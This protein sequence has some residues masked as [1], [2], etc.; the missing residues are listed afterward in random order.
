MNH[1]CL[2]LREESLIIRV[3]EE[4]RSEDGTSAIRKHE[5][6]V[7]LLKQRI[8]SLE[9]VSRACEYVLIIREGIRFLRDGIIRVV[10]SRERVERTDL[11]PSSTEFRSRVHSETADIHTGHRDGEEIEVE[12]L[13][14]RSLE[15]LPHRSVITCPVLHVLS[16]PSNLR[17]RDDEW[18]SVSHLLQ[19]VVCGDTLSEP[20]EVV[21]V[22]LSQ[23]VIREVDC[24]RVWLVVLRC[25]HRHSLL[26]LRVV[27]AAYLEGELR[28]EVLHGDAE[29]L[30]VNWCFGVVRHDALLIRS[31]LAVHEVRELIHINPE[32]ARRD[33]VVSCEVL[34][35]FTP[36][37][38]GS[39]VV[40]VDVV[41]LS[42][43]H[44]SDQVFTSLVRLLEQILRLAEI[45]RVVANGNTSVDNRHPTHTLRSSHIDC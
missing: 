29:V 25:V 26:L 18:Q 19:R 31:D 43:P 7:V 24:Q 16:G 9:R 28:V 39:R 44:A 6:R 27:S 11:V 45:T 15:E 36:V 23:R 35:T 13:L 17:A 38:E 41:H 10:V 22:E 14:E 37:V 42:R 2:V 20:V 4:R 34:Q 21:V 33:V 40:E 30:L 12:D 3:V 5:V 8:S 1:E 32:T